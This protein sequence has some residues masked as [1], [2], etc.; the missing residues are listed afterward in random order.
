MA[1]I[2]LVDKA[3]YEWLM[4][5]EPKHWVKAYFPTFSTCDKSTNNYSEAFNKYILKAR[6]KPIIS[7]L[8]TIRTMLM[9]RMQKKRQWITKQEGKLCPKIKK[10]LT[11]LR[12]LSRSCIP[13][14]CGRLK[15][16]VE[17][18]TVDQFA[19]D[20]EAQTCSCNG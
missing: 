2:K 7:L 10:K 4:T 16:Q 6:D 1:K 8:E 19:V 15:F 20:L 11:L 18:P 14:L 3:A 13:T 17:I 12:Q 5:K 9:K